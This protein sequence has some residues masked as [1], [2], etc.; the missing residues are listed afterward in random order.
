MVFL[1]QIL[2]NYY[3]N[4]GICCIL[5]YLNIHQKELKT[6]QPLFLNTGARLLFVARSIMM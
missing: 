2:F 6:I 4:S 1:N 5:Y 3:E